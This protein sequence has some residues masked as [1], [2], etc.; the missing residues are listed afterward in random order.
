MACLYR[1][2]DNRGITFY[3]GISNNNRRPNDY[4][5]RNRAWKFHAE[6]HGVFTEILTESVSYEEAKELEIILIQFYGRRDLNKGFLMNMT[7]GGDGVVGHSPESIEKIRSVHLGR[8]HS[9]EEIEKRAKKLR[10]RKRS[11]EV[12]KKI[13]ESRTGCEFTKS[14]KKNIS[15][16]L[17]GN[18]P[19]NAK[20]VKDIVTQKEYSSIKKAC[21]DLELKYKTEHSRLKYR[22]LSKKNRLKFI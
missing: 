3:I 1:H 21:A 17:I 2:I 14:H 11:E 6:K 10:G 19:A 12:R 20:K 13:S 9:K 16:A 15:K 5:S 8:K 7:D 4:Y 18:I 22:P